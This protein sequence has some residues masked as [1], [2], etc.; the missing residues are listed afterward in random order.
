MATE[1]EVSADTFA[2]RLSA[3][4]LHCRE[5]GHVWRPSTVVYDRRLRLY[6]RTL[7]CTSCRTERHQDIDS[8]GGV[9][10]NYYSYPNGYLAKNVTE[11]V[12]RDTFRL[13]A[14][15]RELHERE[16]RLG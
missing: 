10:S 4:Q 13:E 12:Y 14:I 16:R 7:R 2:G 3:G 1:D 9:V 5:L 15:L 11:R 8:T 6:T